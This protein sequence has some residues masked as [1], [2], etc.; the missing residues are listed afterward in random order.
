MYGA[1]TH[2]AAAVH[3]LSA[4]VLVHPAVAGPVHT[5]V[6][7]DSIGHDVRP[8]QGT[9]RQTFAVHFGQDG[10]CR[11]DRLKKWDLIWSSPGNEFVMVAVINFPQIMSV[12]EI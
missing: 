9:T 2:A 8:T 5:Y 12:P 7:A 10:T 4:P 6:Y 11:G 3:A 1:R